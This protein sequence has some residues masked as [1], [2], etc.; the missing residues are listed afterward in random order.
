MDAN[1]R[2]SLHVITHLMQH[3]EDIAAALRYAAFFLAWLFKLRDMWDSRLFEALLVGAY[4]VLLVFS[5]A[6]SPE[7]VKH[8]DSDFASKGAVAAAV[9]VVLFGLSQALDD[10]LKLLMGGAHICA[11]FAFF[12]AWSAFPAPSKGQLARHVHSASSFV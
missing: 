5:V 9:A 12:A 4:V 6:Q 3:D 11:G 2:G 1:S 7:R 8:L 10:S